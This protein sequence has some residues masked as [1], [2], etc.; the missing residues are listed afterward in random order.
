MSKG[1]VSIHHSD[2]SNPYQ[3]Q[4]KAWLISFMLITK[5]YKAKDEDEGG[6]EVEAGVD[7]HAAVEWATG[8]V[9]AELPGSG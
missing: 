8:A 7:V 6:K 4:H 5:K 3:L 1:I 9:W 2:E